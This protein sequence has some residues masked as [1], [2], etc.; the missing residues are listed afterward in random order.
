MKASW[1]LC[2]FAGRVPLAAAVLLWGAWWVLVPPPHLPTEAEPFQHSTSGVWLLPPCALLGTVL[3]LCALSVLGHVFL[4]PALPCH[5]LCSL[6][7]FPCADICQWLHKNTYGIGLYRI[8]C[9]KWSS[10]DPRQISDLSCPYTTKAFTSLTWVALGSS[11]VA[12]AVSPLFWNVW[13][14]SCCP[15]LYG[16]VLAAAPQW[17]FACAQHWGVDKYCS[18]SWTLSA[19][20]WGQQEL[21]QFPEPQKAGTWCEAMPGPWEVWLR[22]GLICSVPCLFSLQ[23]WLLCAAMALHTLAGTL[24]WGPQLLSASQGLGL[25]SWPGTLNCDTAGQDSAKGLREVSDSRENFK[26]RL[27]FW[28]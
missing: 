11:F 5:Q 14:L 4:H 15:F 20:N 12:S 22:L 24:P 6:V 17:K 3:A 1:P 8:S 25:Q 18:M 2:Q 7:S 9:V 10:W 19:C 16:W 13:V 23:S 28:K 26:T 27:L 21:E